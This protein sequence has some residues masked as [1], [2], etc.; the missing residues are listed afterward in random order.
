MVHLCL[1]IQ[2]S[3]AKQ[4]S[5]NAHIFYYTTGLVM[6]SQRHQLYIMKKSLN[7]LFFS[8]I[9]E[10]HTSLHILCVMIQPS[11]MFT[12]NARALYLM[13]LSIINDRPSYIYHQSRTG[14]PTEWKQNGN[15]IISIPVGEVFD[16]DPSSTEM[17]L[18]PVSTSISSVNSRIHRIYPCLF[19]EGQHVLRHCGND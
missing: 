9:L 10:M 8:S 13:I 14:I 1:I 2:P 18:E 15:I 17:D 6:Q 5:I 4:T 7:L 11:V 12:S 3:R 19:L 16:T